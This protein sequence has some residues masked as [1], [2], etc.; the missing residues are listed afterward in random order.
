M[1]S[2]NEK[3]GL[4]GKV[5]AIYMDP[6]Y[7]I[8]FGSNWQVSTQKKDVKDNKIEDT[9]RQPEQIRAFRDTWQLGIHSYLSYLRDRL[10]IARELLTTSGSIFVQIGDENVHLV[11]NILDEVFGSENHMSTISFRTT[12]GLGASYLKRTN[13]FIIW[14]AKDKSSV[15]FRRLFREETPGGYNYVEL[16][17]GTLMTANEADNKNVSYTPEQMF[18]SSDLVSSGLTPS[19]VYPVEFEGRTF[20]PGRSRSWKTNKEGMD[21]LKA[22]GRLVALGET[23]RFKTF[24]SDFPVFLRFKREIYMQLTS[25]NYAYRYISTNGTTFVYHDHYTAASCPFLD[26]KALLRLAHLV[27]ARCILLTKSALK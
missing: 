6:P 18:T 5:Q 19:C 1:N 7:G 12:S 20:E 25:H 4:K 16:D 22:A 24:A 21:K 2:L 15:K 26:L 11:R 23:L 10:T 17:D 9:T 14:Y 8:K 3:E 13:D 27:L